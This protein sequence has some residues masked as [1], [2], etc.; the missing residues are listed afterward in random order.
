MGAFSN[1]AITDN[2]RV[3][4]SHVQ[5]GAVFTPTK[6]VMGSGNLPSGTTVRTITDIVTPE[7]TLTISKKKR[8][9]DGTV[10]IGGVYSNQ[11]VTSGFYFRELGLYAKAVYPDGREVEEVLYSYGNAGSTADYMPAYTSGQPVEREIDLVIYIG[12]DT[13]VDLTVDSGVYVTVQQLEEALKDAGG[14]LVVIEQGQDIPI[15]ERKDGFLYFKVTDVRALS[16]TP[17]IAVIFDE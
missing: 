10:A 4:L 16:V 1:N 11:G 3:L 7:Q 5:M 13:D 9:N 14:G 15:A 8:G 17:E 6:I 2:G 12:N